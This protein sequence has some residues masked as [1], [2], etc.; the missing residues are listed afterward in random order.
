MARDVQKRR[1]LETRS[2]AESIIL[3][4][5]DSEFETTDA[6]VLLANSTYVRIELAFAIEHDDN[7]QC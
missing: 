5:I 7:L 1:R 6:A 3:E 4:M 2:T